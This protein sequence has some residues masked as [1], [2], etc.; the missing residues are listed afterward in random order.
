MLWLDEDRAFR[1]PVRT[2]STGNI[3]L[4]DGAQQIVDEL[5]AKAHLGSSTTASDG[6]SRRP[7]RSTPT[8]QC[9]HPALAVIDVS[10]KEPTAGSAH[11]RN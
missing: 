9:S 8:P 2:S 4:R 6:G 11:A 7:R 5:N 10:L 3:K 1:F